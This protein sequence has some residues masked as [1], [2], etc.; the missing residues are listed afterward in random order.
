MIDK[1]Y[2]IATTWRGIIQADMEHFYTSDEALERISEIAIENGFTKPDPEDDPKRYLYDYNDYLIENDI[3]PKIDVS[4]HTI[5]LGE[6]LSMDRT[7]Y[8]QSYKSI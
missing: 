5:N 7:Y 8:Q 4:L 6:E 3:C 1:I 2:V